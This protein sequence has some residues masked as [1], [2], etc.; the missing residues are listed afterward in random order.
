MKVGTIE[1]ITESEDRA[2]K[3]KSSLSGGT[4]GP[5]NG[6]RG[7]GGGGGGGGNGGDNDR[8]G[9]GGEPDASTRTPEKSRILTGFLLLVVTM[10]FGGLVAAYMVIATNRALEWRPFELPIPVWISTIVLLVSSITYYFAKQALDR[11]DQ[12]IAKRWLVATSVLGAAFIA[13]QLLAWLEL[14]NR[15][16]YVAGNS[17]AG[18]FYILTGVHALHVIG[19]IVALGA[20]V[21]RTWDPFVAASDWPRLKT[22]GETVGWYWHFMDAVWVV[23]FVLLGFWK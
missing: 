7:G 16:L 17:Y 4:S 1:P 15:G 5:K 18:F 22:L 10:T 14:Q 13:S 3:R 23:L 12:P 2:A 19:G 8:G 11:E 9:F 21:L 6:G 20:V